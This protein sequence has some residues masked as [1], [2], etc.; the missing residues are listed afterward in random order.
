MTQ[1]NLQKIVSVIIPAYNYAHF[2]PETLKSVRQQSF[3]H[4][5]CIIV[6]DG[7]TDNTREVVAGYLA[8]DTRFKYIYQKNKGLSAARNTGIKEACGRYLQFL[9]A[10]D[11]LE[12]DK[13]TV[14]VAFMEEHSDIDLV[15]SEARFFSTEHPNERLYSIWGGNKPWMAKVSGYGKKVLKALLARNIMVVSSPLVRKTVIGS[16][17]LFDESLRNHEDWDLWL[18]CAL[19][20][21]IF[22]FLDAENTHTLIRYHR[23]SMSQSRRKM[24]ETNLAIRNKL[25]MQLK[26]KEL[27]QVN[28]KYSNK[29][30]FELALQDIEKDKRLAA[31]FHLLR[32]CFEYDCLGKL[33]YGLKFLIK[34]NSSLG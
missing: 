26:E 27:I 28:R 11:L 24:F 9:D 21:K 3:L 8:T 2:L 6:D 7:S 20:G 12:S 34:D 32:I 29:I 25:A 17:G 13:L 15:Y 30:A 23:S 1:R 33:L 14:Q 16:C 4:W 31:F 5:E 18:R 22:H 19:Q 10:D